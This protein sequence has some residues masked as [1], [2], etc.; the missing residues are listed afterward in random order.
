MYHFADVYLYHDN[1]EIYKKIKITDANE[2]FPFAFR[3]E[4]NG[5]I[6]GFHLAPHSLNIGYYEYVTNLTS[7][8]KIL[9]LTKLIKYKYFQMIQNLYEKIDHES[10]S[11]FL[12][13]IQTIVNECCTNIETI[14][15]NDSRDFTSKK[16]YDELESD[17][18][19]AIC[20]DN[21]LMDVS[22]PKQ[23]VMICVYF[24]YTDYLD[25]V[26][27]TKHIVLVDSFVCSL[28]YSNTKY[29]DF[30][31]EY[32]RT[33]LNVVPK[34]SLEEKHYEFIGIHLTTCNNW[35]IESIETLL[36][37]GL[38]DG[39]DVFEIFLNSKCQDSST[40]SCFESLDVP[41]PIYAPVSINSNKWYTNDLQ[42][43]LKTIKKNNH[44]MFNIF[45]QNPKIIFENYDIIKETLD[46]VSHDEDNQIRNYCYKLMG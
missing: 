1:V 37:N 14:C 19:L 44:I 27:D 39:R 38:I 22:N 17:S 10:R 5:F 29:F 9:F 35:L 7:Q 34:L 3:H 6:R 12:S 2:T 18:I 20:L 31:L 40:R 41:A 4:F 16:F 46:S 21:F 15:M 30:L 13:D 36:D 32:V 26:H 42:L 25:K 8:D 43:V 24:G 28:G 45:K 33:K 23:R 11:N